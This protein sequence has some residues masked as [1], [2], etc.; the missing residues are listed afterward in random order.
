MTRTVSRLDD[1]LS[2]ICEIGSTGSV[3]LWFHELYDDA[4][5]VQHSTKKMKG[6]TVVD[7]V[8]DLRWEYGRGEIVAVVALDRVSSV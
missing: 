4:I 7:K 8:K 1:F 6:A 5:L 3:F 2:Q